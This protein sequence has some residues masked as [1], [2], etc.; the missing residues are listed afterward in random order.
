[1]RGADLDGCRPKAD[2]YQSQLNRSGHTE[3]PRNLFHLVYEFEYLWRP[4]AER[5]R[6][7]L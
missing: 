6:I 2:T 4:T 1:M 5:P 3:A 7:Q